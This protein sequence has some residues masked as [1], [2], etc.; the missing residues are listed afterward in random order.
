MRL[1]PIHEKRPKN[2]RYDDLIG[3]LGGLFFLAMSEI[4][5]NWGVFWLM[6]G[7][8]LIVWSVGSFLYRRFRT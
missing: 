8:L 7:V 2:R 6:A 4:D 3:L 1:K 5:R